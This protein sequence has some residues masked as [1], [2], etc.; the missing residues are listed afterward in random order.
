ME[1]GKQ[2][3]IFNDKK[4]LG[5]LVIRQF[6]RGQIRGKAP[7][8]P[9]AAGLFVGTGERLIL[10]CLLLCHHLFR[11]SGSNS[12]SLAQVSA[13]GEKSSVKGR[14][15]GRAA[16][17]REAS[18]PARGMAHLFGVCLVE[19]KEAVLKQRS[20]E[21]RSAWTQTSQ[22][23]LGF[24]GRSVCVGGRPLTRQKVGA[25]LPISLACCL[26]CLPRRGD[27]LHRINRTSSRAWNH[28]T[29]GF[30]G[31]QGRVG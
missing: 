29:R 8:E 30:V 16:A 18:H 23:P 19:K 31:Q 22:S 10:V 27:G 9:L 5:E 3:Y 13:A 4:R 12:P 15:P 17:G 25:H 2:K 21:P 28:Q 11:E 6:P 24:S 14:G 20:G 26:G 1:L 7:R